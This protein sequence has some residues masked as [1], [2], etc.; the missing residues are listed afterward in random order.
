MKTKLPVLFIFVCQLFFLQTSFSQN[1]KL[2]GT[3]INSN[4]NIPVNNAVIALLS[5]KDST[6]L[7]YTR[8]DQSGK[9]LLQVPKGDYI[10]MTSQPYFGDLLE[11]ITL[12]GDKNISSVK[13]ISK[14]TLLQEVIIK[15]GSP[16]R[17]KGDTTIYTADSF[18]VSANANVEEL[19]KKLP[20]IQVDKDGKIKAMGENVEKVLVDGEEFFGDD[21]G[22]TIKNLRADGVKE[23]QVFDKKSEQSEFTGIDD[24]QTKK[25]INLKLKENAKKGYF[26]KVDIAA[27]PQ[28]H[29]DNR[30][31]TNIMFSSFKGKRKFSSFLLNGN[32]GQDRMSWQ[33]EQKFGDMGDMTMMDDGGV[34]ITRSGSQDDEP[35]IDPNN[36]FMYNVNTGLLYSNKWDEKH[37]LNLSPKFNQQIYDNYKTTFI[38]TQIGDS[39]LN[40]NAT[41]T[42]HANR[43]NFKLKGIWEFK[44][45]SM[46]TLKVTA[47]SNFYHTESNVQSNSISTGNTG[48]LKNTSDKDVQT[49]S[50]KAALSGNILFK[51]KFKKDRRTI[52]LNA[53]WNSLENKGST[54]VQSNN[55]SYFNGIPSG[56]QILNQVKD[57]KTSTNNLSAGLVY[58][59]PLSKEFSLELGYRFVLNEGTNEQT[60]NGYSPATQKY[61]HLIDT[62]TNDFKQNIIQNIPSAKINFANKKWKLNIGAGFGF[63]NFQLKD[64]TLNKNYDRNYTNFF[65][66]ATATYTYKPNHSIRF[67]YNGNTTQPTINQLQPLRNN[68]DY[69]NQYIGNPNLKPSFTNSF[70]VSHNSYNFLKNL[71]G[72]Q[73]LNVRFTNNSITNNRVIN[74]ESGKTITQPINT[75]GNLSI[76]FYGGVGFKLKKLD[77]NVT[78]QPM[79]AYSQ[80]SDVI[81]NVKSLSKAFTPTMTVYMNKTKEN[82]YDVS[83]SNSYSYNSN[84]SSQND[85]KLHYFTNELSLNTTVYIQKVWSIKND[86]T[87]YFRQKTFSTDNDISTHIWNARL[88][89]TFKSNEFTAYVAVN[90]ILNQNVGISRSFN[91]NTYRE[92]NNDRLKRYFM[93]GFTWNFKNKSANAK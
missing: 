89:R 35:Y 14:A 39:S 93:I 66:N 53:D 90:D 86:Y 4:E 70:N 59:E 81:N 37:S 18:K 69:Y 29:I 16:F 65:P 64:L 45:D 50:D 20:G 15:S 32:T 27:G 43:Y 25:T 73:A 68:D 87:Y 75:D 85:T 80:F 26:G 23:V 72:Y 13:L 10:M 76:Y 61:D 49:K 51:H 71:W 42:S 57:Y 47:N 44:M 3:V 34:M 19:L 46:N 5:P 6:L 77:I 2:S 78:L 63:T 24:G 40:Q 83:V 41:E 21:P 79:I 60:T 28:E 52:T 84:I 58:T 9:F 33:D 11:D 8:S 30:Y 22:M 36:G 55:Q 62:L 17:I 1:V 74:V 54:L 31:N 82:K 88:Q 7:K 91:G 56:G 38:K 12:D 48:T 92:V 67:S